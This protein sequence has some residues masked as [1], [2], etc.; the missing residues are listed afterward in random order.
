M[1]AS[2]GRRSGGGGGG[3]APR[4]AG[5]GELCSRGTPP[6]RR[7]GCQSMQHPWECC[8]WLQYP[9]PGHPDAHLKTPRPQFPAC[10]WTASLRGR[11][12][13]AST[14][15]SEGPCLQRGPHA[16]RGSLPA[17]GGCP[18]TNLPCPPP[19]THTTCPPP[20]T[21]RYWEP[22]F[23]DSM[24]LIAKLPTIAAT[25]YRCAARR[26]VRYTPSPSPPQLPQP[27]IAP[28]RVRQHRI[29]CLPRLGASPAPQ[30]HL[31]GRQPDR[32]RPCPGLGRQPGAH[33]G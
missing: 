17:G 6:A 24:D 27:A 5:P 12:G 33:D 3:G 1:Q 32:G 31:Q 30:Q 9:W 8:T 7:A 14:S 23:E 19:H 20:S 26:C 25:I 13:R 11:T 22:V 15:P 29:T 28:H 2:R 16:G 18:H 10:R 21:Q 4:L